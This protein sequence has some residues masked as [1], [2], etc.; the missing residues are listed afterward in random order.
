MYLFGSKNSHSMRHVL[1]AL[2]FLATLV[3][4]AHITVVGGFSAASTRSISRAETASL[5]VRSPLVTNGPPSTRVQEKRTHEARNEV[6]LFNGNGNGSFDISK[7]QFDLYS[8]RNIRGDALIRYN[9]LNQ[10]EPLRI[11]LYLLALLSLL[12]YPTVSEA[13]FGEPAT[14]PG[15]IAAAAGAVFSGYRFYRECGRRS[16]KLSKMEKELNAELLTVQIANG[17]FAD[18]LYGNVRF[19]LKDMRGKRR[20]LAVCGSAAQLREA[21]T[22]FRTLRRRF[23]QASVLV[24]AV[25]TDGSKSKEWGID[26]AE[27]R[28]V[29]YLAQAGDSKEW[30]DYFASLVG[31]DDDDDNDDDS[32]GK[33][34]DLG[35]KIAWF[36]LSN[37]GK[38]FG[39]GFGDALRPIEILG[40][41]LLPLQN[42]DEDDEDDIGSTASDDVVSILAA[43]KQFYQAL[44]SGDRAGMD[45]VYSKEES[46]EVDE[47]VAGGGG[48]DSWEKCLE[49]G[50]RPSGMKI[51][52]SDVFVASTTEAYSTTIEFPPVDGIEDATLLAVQ[53][54]G[55][56]TVD[57]EW[58]LELHQTIPWSPSTRAGATLRCDR[59]GCTALTREV[60]RQYNFRGM[61]D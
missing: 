13:V 27:I 25:S 28:S 45:Q 18:R 14:L 35:G 42:L 58:K 6:C 21:L 23:A 56:S 60:D 26:D 10:S 22:P 48:I 53:K 36:G 7:D 19:S 30:V 46:G 51:S 3:L 40:Q 44:T 15:T 4:N 55:R 1:S 61:I 32:G 34:A 52:G 17:P 43:Q 2:S 41:S 31:G 49:D 24:V 29:N 12:S 9:T 37:S 33:V 47:V 38:S 59:R 54:W 20:I 16:R 57:D 8:L 11:N 39:S 5:R 50:A